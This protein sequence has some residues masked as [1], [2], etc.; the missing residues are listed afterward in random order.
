MLIGI[1]NEL[2]SIPPPRPIVKA[3]EPTKKRTFFACCSKNVAN[4]VAENRPKEHEQT[5]EDPQVDN[6]WQMPPPANQT[7]LDSNIFVESFKNYLARPVY[8]H[9]L[10]PV[11]NASSIVVESVG[12]ASQTYVAGPVY[13]HVLEP[14]G[15]ASQ[16]YVAG[17][18]VNASQTYVAGPIYSH[19]VE[20]VGSA[21]QQ[22]VIAPVG[23]AVG[24]GQQQPPLTVPDDKEQKPQPITPLKN[25]DDLA[26]QQ[27][28][29]P[30]HNQ[31]PIRNPPVN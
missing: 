29:P 3:P 11:G 19:V 6:S 17:P 31:P 26:Q 25:P 23:S 15:S 1:A 13:S 30:N 18:I 20:P 5:V 9:V 22:Y 2:K 10:E 16:T 7:W 21:T 27:Q 4:Q 12:N 8:S 14:V 24:T 28:H